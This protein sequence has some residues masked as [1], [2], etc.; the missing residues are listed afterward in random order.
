MGTFVLAK[1]R[2]IKFEI[3]YGPGILSPDAIARRNLLSNS[4]QLIRAA[5]SRDLILSSGASRAAGCRGPADVVNLAAT[6][7]LGQEK[8]HEAISKLSRS[9]VV[10]AKLKRTSY[11]GAV[12][13][14]YGGEKK[15]AQNQAVQGSTKASNKRKAGDAELDNESTVKPMSKSQQKRQRKAEAQAQAGHEDKKE[16]T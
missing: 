4:A 2:G 11:R 1:E 14:I 9:V 6:W 8:G 5:R 15:E 16:K 7:G 12:N 10:V 13:V 3:C